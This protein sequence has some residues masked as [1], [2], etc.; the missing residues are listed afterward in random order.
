MEVLEGK[1][2]REKDPSGCGRIPLEG[3]KTCGFTGEDGRKPK[4]VVRETEDG[5]SYCQG[6]MCETH[7]LKRTEGTLWGSHSSSLNSHWD[8]GVWLSEEAL[9]WSDYGLGFHSQHSLLQIVT[10]KADKSRT[11]RQRNYKEG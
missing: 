11:A 9:A 8:S 2:G 5:A 7:F 10:G 4:Q 3:V 6:D 1:C